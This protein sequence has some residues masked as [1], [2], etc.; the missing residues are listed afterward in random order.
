MS[1]DRRKFSIS[2]LLCSMFVF[3]FPAE[4]NTPWLRNAPLCE[5]LNWNYIYKQCNQFWIFTF[6]LFKTFVIFSSDFIPQNSDISF[7]DFSFSWTSLEYSMHRTLIP[8]KS[9]HSN[10]ISFLCKHSSFFQPFSCN[11]WCRL[12]HSTSWELLHRE[13]S[14]FPGKKSSNIKILKQTELPADW[15]P[16][17]MSTWRQVQSGGKEGAGPDTLNDRICSCLQLSSIQLTPSCHWVDI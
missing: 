14:M 5:S 15:V 17:P 11:L 13:D 6:N 7:H 3:T 8:W 12:S 4:D 9:I 1:K 16:W 10:N 2:F